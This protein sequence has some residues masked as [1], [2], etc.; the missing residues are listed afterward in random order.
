MDR[1]GELKIREKSGL[2]KGVMEGGISTL[3]SRDDT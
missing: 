3:L 1:G 2:G